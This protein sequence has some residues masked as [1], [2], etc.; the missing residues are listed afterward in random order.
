MLRP[1][2]G[3]LLAV[4]LLAACA[5]PDAGDGAESGGSSPTT[6][7]ETLPTAPTTSTTSPGSPGTGQLTT[8]GTLR[9]GVEPGCVL[10]HADQG[11]IYLLV[12]GDRTRMRA[13]GRVQVTGR[14]APDL[15][16]TCQQ[17][18]PLL[19]SAIEPVP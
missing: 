14:H 5:E 10:L 15:L 16:S 1:L 12:G 4:A 2:T 19:V 13:G 3:L 7:P 11:P 17:G 9:A 18:E 8:T 6:A